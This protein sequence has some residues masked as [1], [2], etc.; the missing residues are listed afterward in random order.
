MYGQGQVKW[1]NLV[2]KLLNFSVQG[3]QKE[4]LTL[5]SGISN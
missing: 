5:L 2:I 1:G 3:N 4:I